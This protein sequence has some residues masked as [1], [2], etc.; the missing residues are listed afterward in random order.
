[1]T[2]GKF[3]N[4]DGLA[5]VVSL[6]LSPPSYFS[7]SSILCSV[8]CPPLARADALLLVVPPL[9]GGDEKKRIT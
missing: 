1:M 3:H 6:Q 8:K 2:I 7:L 4:S 5:A 9:P